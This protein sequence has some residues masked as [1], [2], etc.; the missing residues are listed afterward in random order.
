MTDV[1]FSHGHHL[2]GLDRLRCRE[3]TEPLQRDLT[4]LTAQTRVYDMK[5]TLKCKVKSTLVVCRLVA[6][7]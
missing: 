2:A 7:L 6:A 4:N 5:Q 1:A 3:D